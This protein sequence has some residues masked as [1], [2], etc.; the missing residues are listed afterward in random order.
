MIKAISKD[1]IE[2]RILF[3]ETILMVDREDK[4]IC[5]IKDKDLNFE[6]NFNVTFSDD[7]KE[8]STTGSSSDDGKEINITL[9]KWQGS[10]GTELTKPIEYKVNDKRI[11]IKFKTT[12][13]IKNNFRGFHLTIWGEK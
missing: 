7:G 11:W 12:A 13:D 6:F 4:L 9:H 3:N 8:L 1:G 10:V 2:R 5:N